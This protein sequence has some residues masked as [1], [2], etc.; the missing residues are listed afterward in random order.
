V[1][2]RWTYTWVMTMDIKAYEFSGSLYGIALMIPG[3]ICM[4]EGKPYIC[5]S[6]CRGDRACGRPGTPL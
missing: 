6:V 4:G 3:C 2:G 5:I 1:G